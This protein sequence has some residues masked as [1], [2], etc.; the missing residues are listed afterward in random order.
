MT[1]IV[2]LAALLSAFAGAAAGAEAAPTAGDARYA[3]PARCA[4][5]HH[6][7]GATLDPATARLAAVDQ[8]LLRHPA[9]VPAETKVPFL[10]NRSLA[11]REI[12]IVTSFE[13]P[14]RGHEA[15]EP[16]AL[17]W[18][19][20]ARWD[21]RD[22]W[23]RPQYD[24]L[25]ELA[26]ARQI[27]LFL[28][29]APAADT[30][31]E[32]LLVLIRYEGTVYDSLRP[33]PESYQRGFETTTGLIDPRG[34]Y[35]SGT[36]LW[37]PQ[38]FDDPFP[39]RL[40]VSVPPDW[41]AISQ[42]RRQGGE[43]GAPRVS[44]ISDEPM[45]EI[46]LI[47][48]PYR[49]REE[50]HGE[51]AI[52]TFTYGN[53]DDEL[54]ARYLQ[55]TRD[56]LDLYAEKIGPYPF[57]KFALVE[58]FWQ[59]GYGMPS[60]TLLGDRVIRLPF[61][62][63]TSYGHEILHNWWGNSVFVDYE[64]GNWCEGLTVYG[65]DYLYKE[66]E[67]PAAARDYR[68]A[69]LVEY[70]NYVRSG[71]D[72]PL[73]EFR[74]R[75]DA[76]SAAVGYGKSMM[77]YHMLRQSMGDE[78]FWSALRAFY[79][80]NLFE[81]A[82]WSDLLAVF[83]GEVG[84]AGSEMPRTQ[85]GSAVGAV[86]EAQQA[87][88]G[89]AINSDLERFDAAA[90]A[91]QWIERSGAPEIRLATTDLLPT[92]DGRYQIVYV[93]EQ[94]A[95]FYR[96]DV[97]IRATYAVLP[98]TVWTVRLETG[99]LRETREL[100]AMPRTLEVDPDFDLFRRLHRAEVPAVLSQLYGADS[101]TFVLGS[102]GSAPGPD[103]WRA[104]AEEAR[105]GTPA[106]IVE[107]GSISLT[108][109]T[110]G[111]AWIF[112]EPG[113]MESLATLLPDSVRIDGERFVVSGTSYPRAENTLALVVPNPRNPDEAIGLLIGG[114]AENLPGIWRKLPHY[115]KYS[116]LVFAGTQNVAK[117]IWDTGRSPLKMVWS[118]GG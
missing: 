88:D 78:R 81:R 106:G 41:Q 13:D 51:V 16:Y 100:P 108:D 75:H 39:F 92:K 45:D 28:A 76:S 42:G 58:N 3:N 9:G 115:G 53:D 57:P 8:V 30:W 5:S 59:T 113:W 98:P 19:E 107:T 43:P 47:A 35:L 66:R 64:S 96:L 103:A 91:E 44:W 86:S 87:P 77:I 110:K 52:Q 38:R 32:S 23:E 6:A 109:L 104:L 55:G 80:E 117:G 18:E 116:Y 83:A 56:Y 85:S 95:P 46:Y 65:A 82:S 74:E 89:A 10:L 71:R 25:A 27:D 31:P 118:T 93:L 69:Q 72:F 61:I 50:H 37:Y 48:G 114:S 99:S 24:D 14:Q 33:P 62:L 70:L 111:G 105:Q 112:G 68:R 36:S 90:F 97:P 63:G 79:R 94:E 60:F 84:A 22:F 4:F 20:S 73:T 101:L 102:E 49:L 17:R 29:G 7:I 11:I 26:H 15:S 2:I 12:R 40:D 1:R 54:C 67:G 21:P 34:A